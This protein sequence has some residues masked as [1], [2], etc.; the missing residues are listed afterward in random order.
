ML[1]EEAVPLQGESGEVALLRGELRKQ[2]R[3]TLL[4]LCVAAIA[5]VAALPQSPALAALTMAKPPATTELWAGPDEDIVPEDMQ[6]CLSAGWPA[7]MAPVRRAGDFLYFSGLLGYSEPCKK[8]HEDPK[9][10]VELAFE[11]MD[12]V[13]S[14]AGVKWTDLLSVTSYHVNLDDHLDMFLTE[15]EKYLPHGPFP[16]WS[17]VVVEKLFFEHE[18]LEMSAVARLPP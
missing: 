7:Q 14:E 9:K 2:Q 4:A 13:L 15:R 3:V 5:L 6:F 8:A 12:K 17:S 10:Q 1:S 18:I 11:W 16:A